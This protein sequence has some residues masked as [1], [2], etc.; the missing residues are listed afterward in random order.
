MKLLSPQ[1]HFSCYNYDKGQNAALEILMQPTESTIE[2][3]LVDTEIVFVVDGHFK[4]SFSKF[5][6]LDIPKG[7][8]L[9]FPPGS[10]IKADFTDE[11]HL[12]ICRTRGIF[13]LCEC[14]PIEYLYNTYGNKKSNRFQMLDINE[15]IYRYIDDFVQCVNDGLYCTYY[16]S[17]K[18]K[19]LFFL[20]RAYYSKEDLAA[21][22]EPLM[23]PNSRFMDLMYKNH[24]K[25]KNVQEL[26]QISM[27]SSSGFKKQFSKVF[28][29]SA[30]EW[31]REQKAALIFQDLNN[32]SLN[33]KELADKYQF[34]SVSS[35]STFCQGKFG[36][37]PGKIRKKQSKKE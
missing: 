5:V 36:I 26:A 17:T 6:D 10:H 23:S 21:F 13:Q 32:S 9:F 18:I 14:L 35:F 24:R 27:Y 19:E 22:F 2:R 1:E 25:V 7:K 12:I 37:S 8:I 29:T 28:G 4:L 20:L 34:S 11:T 16:F 30:S 15:R 33:I 31:L 3:D